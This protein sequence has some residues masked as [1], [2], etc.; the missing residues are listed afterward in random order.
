MALKTQSTDQLYEEM[1]KNKILYIKQLLLLEIGLNMYNIYKETF[2]SAL[3]NFFTPITRPRSLR[4]GSGLIGDKPR[5]HL[6]KQALGY[7]GPIIWSNTPNFV[8]YSSDRG[9][10]LRQFNDFKTNLK[11]YILCLGIAECK[12]IIDALVHN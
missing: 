5:I 2:P 12:A 9:S 4:S 1:E 11:T 3:T 7:K 6:T 8:K 10:N